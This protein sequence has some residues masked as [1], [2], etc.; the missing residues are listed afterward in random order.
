[1]KVLAVLFQFVALQIMVTNRKLKPGN[2]KEGVNVWLFS[3][4]EILFVTNN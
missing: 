1:M 4:R 3:K 2:E